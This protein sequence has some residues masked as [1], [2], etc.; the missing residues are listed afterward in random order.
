VI[1]GFHAEMS[2][3]ITNE[4]PAII[5]SQHTRSPMA[6]RHT[7]LKA[8]THKNSAS[9]APDAERGIHSLR[10]SNPQGASRSECEQQGGCSE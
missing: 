1:V 7:T 9:N 4:A 2:V 5:P 8:R 6:R 10:R 3:P